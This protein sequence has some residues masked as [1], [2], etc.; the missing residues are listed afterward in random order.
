MFRPA[1]AQHD[2]FARFAGNEDF[3]GHVIGFDHLWCW[4]RIHRDQPSC[5]LEFHW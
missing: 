3:K 5:S 1:V 2:G 4:K